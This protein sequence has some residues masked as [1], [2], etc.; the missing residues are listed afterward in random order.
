RDL[1]IELIVHDQAERAL[2][3]GERVGSLL[4]APQRDLSREIAGT[5]HHVRKNVGELSIAHG[6]SG[7]ALLQ[8]H[9]VAPVPDD[10][11]EPLPKRDE[12]VVLAPVEG[13][14]LRVLAEAHEGEAEV[15]PAALLIDLEAHG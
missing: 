3:L 8:A 5:L 1:R 7:E 9:D 12:L 10:M 2:D 11:G 4:Q 13:D 15:G 6:E 14:A